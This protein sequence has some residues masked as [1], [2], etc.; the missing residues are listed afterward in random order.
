M[1]LQGF[2]QIRSSGELKLF[3]SHREGI[4]DGEQKRDFIWVKDVVEVML[5]ALEKPIRRGIFNLG[6]GRAR[7]FLDLAHA[8]FAA[9]G[10]SPRIHFIDTPAAI[11]DRYQYFTEAPMGKLRAEGYAVPFASLEDGVLETVRVLERGC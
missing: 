2:D 4:A 5:F 9:M 6:T 1:V 8:T 10:K 11:R 7:S 3:R